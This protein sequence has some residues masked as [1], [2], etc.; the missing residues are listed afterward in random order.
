[1]D[2]DEFVNRSMALEKPWRIEG[3][4]IVEESRTVEIRVVY[5][6]SEGRCPECGKLCKRHDAN[7]RRWRHLD[8]LHYQTW[9]TCQVP[10]VRCDEHKVRRIDVPW[11]DGWARFSA[12]FECVVIDWLKDSSMTAV[13]RNFGLS[14]DQVNGIQ[15]RAV[16]RG[17]SRREAVTP[18]KI[19]V[20]ETS[21][22]KRHEY[23]TIVTDLDES[24][25]LHVA[26]G[27]G[28]ESLDGFFK[29]LSDDQLRGIDLIAMDMHQPYIYSAAWYLPR[30]LEKICF[31]RFHVAQLLSKAV[32][33]TRRSEVKRLANEGDDS[34]KG[35][36]YLW[37]Q[38]LAN[39]PRKLRRQLR[40]AMESSASVAEV[41]AIKEAASKLWNYKSKTWARKAW[42]A[43]ATAAR[44]VTSA[45]LNKAIDTI[46]RHLFGIINAIVHRIS[47]AGSESINGRVQA[48]KRR[49]NGYRRRAR[50]RDAIMFHLGGL[51]LYPAK[52]VPLEC[53]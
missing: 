29:G 20:D 3:A 15:E 40:H 8:M 16:K 14:W 53:Q 33:Q 1:M 5:D 28:R 25:V 12:R 7:E 51:D 36:R 24:R 23:V 18:S 13:A 4:E 27:R 48:L 21:F 30:P 43:F 37:L 46:L 50:F 47:N 52:A 19:G 9:I 10:R 32:D 2:L 34:L 22:Q 6:S 42:T 35:T 41:W 26:D 39:M 11:S 17:L 38:T 31:D 45:A 49:A 44:Q